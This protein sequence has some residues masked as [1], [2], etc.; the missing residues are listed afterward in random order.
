MASLLGHT[1]ENNPDCANG[2]VLDGI[3]RSLSEAEDVERMLKA[4][5]QKLDLVIELSAD[6]ALLKSR[7]SGCLIHLL[8]GRSY[9]EKFKPP[10]KYMKDDITG[11]HLVGCKENK[12]ETLEKQLHVFQSQRSPVIDYYRSSGIWKNIDGS[13]EPPEVWRKLAILLNELVDRKKNQNS[14]F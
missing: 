9:H 13:Q 11:E 4:R 6:E 5:Q 10:K 1:I 8:S 7:E 14:N 12:P 2:F 3:P